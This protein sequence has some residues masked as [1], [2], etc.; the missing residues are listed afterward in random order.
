MNSNLFSESLYGA[1]LVPMSFFVP[2]PLR[3]PDLFY[4]IVSN[5]GKLY[6]THEGFTYQIRPNG[7]DYLPA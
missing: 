3:H 4:K 7:S 1:G 2:N 6:K 5:G